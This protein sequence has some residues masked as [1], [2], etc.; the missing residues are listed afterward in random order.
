MTHRRSVRYAPHPASGTLAGLSSAVGEVYG[1]AM[2]KL[3]D[4]R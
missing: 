2:L 3:E 1:T 4:T